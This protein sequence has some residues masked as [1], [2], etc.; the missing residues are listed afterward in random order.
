MNVRSTVMRCVAA[1]AVLALGAADASAD[2][3]ADFYKGKNINLVI[4]SGE[5]ASYDLVG[6]LVGQF[7][8]RHIPG[9]P[10]I[11][12]R[13]M[14]GA[15]SVRATEYF[16]NVMQRDGTS[17]AFVQPTVV[18]NKITDPNAKYEPHEFKWLGRVGEVVT[19][20]VVWHT[21]PALTVEE[22]KSKEVVF[23]AAG[24]SG[25]AAQIPWAL[26]RLVGTKF[27]VVRGYESMATEILAMER[28]EVQGIGSLV[29]DYFPVSKPD[30]VA[31]K[32]VRPIYTISLTR[33]RSLP[34]V[35][36]I[37]EL[38][39][40]DL[41]R[42]V[43]KLF[44]GTLSIGYAVATTP[45]VPAD[46]LAALRQAFEAVVKD[47]EFIAEAKKRETDVD[48]LPGAELDKIVAELVAMPREVVA[49]MNEVIQPPP[50]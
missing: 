21:A 25:Y 24:A 27:N 40:N 17:L 45:G 5:G 20:G 31:N 44:G 28:G 41:D 2:A 3:V 36:T 32:T 18:L 48:P 29:W 38:A 50:R 6:R 23:G 14:P 26:N 13:N 37:V 19:V 46:R 33:H 8:Q 39:S 35:P 49:K 16:Y 12:P 11:V 47:P 10:T 7:L 9:N 22:A 30:W 1:A 34:D 4:G 15:S 42:N 43:M